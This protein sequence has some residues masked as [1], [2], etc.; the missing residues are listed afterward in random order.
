[1]SATVLGTLLMGT[2]ASA[3]LCGLYFASNPFFRDNNPLLNAGG[4]YLVPVGFIL[5]I[6]GAVIFAASFFT[7]Y[8]QQN[9]Q[10]ASIKKSAYAIVIIFTLVA[11]GGGLFVYYQYTSLQSQY[12]S[13]LAQYNW[14]VAQPS[15]SIADLNTYDATAQVNCSIQLI[16][17]DF[18]LV[19]SGQVDGFATIRISGG[20]NTWGENIYFV[21]AGGTSQKSFMIPV[22][23]EQNFKT[24]VEVISV[25]R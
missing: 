1:M 14:L 6:L 11:A 7:N 3:W 12:N 16:G 21:P 15:I 5:G 17:A 2:G 18:T 22:G 9:V 24:W 13:L 4:Q 25:K 10:K 23:C 20:G 8:Y 19:N